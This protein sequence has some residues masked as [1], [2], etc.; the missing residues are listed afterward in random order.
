MVYFDLATF[1]VTE[2]RVTNWCRHSR[3]SSGSETYI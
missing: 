1:E 2:I 3:N